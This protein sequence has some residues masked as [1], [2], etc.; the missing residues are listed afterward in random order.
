MSLQLS[1]YLGPYFLCTPPPYN[2]VPILTQGCPNCKII[3]EEPYCSKCGSKQE[4]WTK[5]NAYASVI[6]FQITEYCK[7]TLSFVTVE[8]RS[9]HFYIPN[10]KCLSREAHFDDAAYQMIDYDAHETETVLFG[11]Q[12]HMEYDT[13]L[14]S[15]D[16]QAVIEWGLLAYHS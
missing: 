2:T 7:Y 6:P 15:Y 5:E 8:G 3:H 9:P 12:F 4:V 13:L 14:K 11:Q 10:V 1:V 16:G